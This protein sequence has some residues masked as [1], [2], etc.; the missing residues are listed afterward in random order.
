[1]VLYSRL[2]PVKHSESTKTCVFTPDYMGQHRNGGRGKIERRKR[3]DLG[4]EAVRKL[5]TR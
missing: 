5:Q 3:E 1:M 2:L 4:N